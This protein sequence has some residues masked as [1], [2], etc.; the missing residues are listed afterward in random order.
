MIIDKE[1]MIDEISEA[2]EQWPE[3]DNWSYGSDAF[4]FPVVMGECHGWQIFAYYS[5]AELTRAEVTDHCKNGIYFVTHGP[6]CVK[7][8]RQYVIDD[9]IA[10]AKTCN[11]H[12]VERDQKGGLSIFEAADAAMQQGIPIDCT[13]MP[14]RTLAVLEIFF[15]EQDTPKPWCMEDLTFYS[16]AQVRRTHGMGKVTMREVKECLDLYGLR[17][18][19]QVSF[20]RHR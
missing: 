19:R 5:D 3:I 13:D 11:L 14:I 9:T 1:A 16:E 20:D 17:F 15:S 6:F 7:K 10:R 2:R 8:A 4:D 18:G 12:I